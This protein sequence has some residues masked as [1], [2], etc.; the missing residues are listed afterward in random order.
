MGQLVLSRRQ[1]ERIIIGRG[2]RQITLTVV[3]VYA[4]GQV[5]IAIDCP[6]DVEVDREEVRLRKD[7]EA[8]R[9]KPN[10]LSSPP[11]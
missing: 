8:M 4:N 6:K 3:E 2:P 11:A 1:H 9:W 7:Q 5:R 10:D